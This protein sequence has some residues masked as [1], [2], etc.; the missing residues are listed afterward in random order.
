[1]NFGF[2]F[3]LIAKPKPLKSGKICTSQR[4]NL[5]LYVPPIL[6]L[7]DLVDPMLDGRTI[8]KNFILFYLYS[9]NFKSNIL[10]GRFCFTL[11]EVN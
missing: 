6:L 11:S 10:R 4:L 9:K 3:E 1:M 7:T 8:H 5:G 2:I